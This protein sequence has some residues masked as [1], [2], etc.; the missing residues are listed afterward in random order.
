LGSSPEAIQFVKVAI[1]VLSIADY[2]DRNGFKV[3]K[4]IVDNL[5]DRMVSDK[6]FDVD[7]HI[8]NS[9]ADIY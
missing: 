2:L 9:R 1:G 8:K 6:N 7:E 4:V 5:A 3:I